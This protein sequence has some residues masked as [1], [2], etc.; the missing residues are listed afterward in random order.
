M[1]DPSADIPGAEPDARAHEATVWFARKLEG[2]AA[3]DRAALQAWL[4]ADPRNAEA[5]DRVE[6]TWS[7]LGR[8]GA[9]LRKRPQRAPLSRRSLGKTALGLGALGV[10]AGA[11]YLLM[12]PHPLADLR[13]AKGERR[14]DTL[15]DGTIV[16]LS[17]ATALTLRFTDQERRVVLHAGEAFFQVAPDPARPFV[18]EAARG[19]SIA[20]GTAY[21]VRREERAVTVTVVEHVVEVR[22]RASSA[23]VAAGQQVRYADDTGVEP[24][25]AAD[26]NTTLAWRGGQLVFLQRP[27]REVVAAIDAWRPGRTLLLDAG[28]GE[29]PVTAVI[30]VR[31]SETI[32]GALPRIAP[33]RI[34]H[35]TP[36][37]TLLYKDDRRPSAT[38]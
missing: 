3:Q 26:P 18:V 16:D 8:A 10:A 2:M 33:V 34:A 31:R 36:W 19:E 25:Q 7:A 21:A 4:A 5:L 38:P 6:R 28:L 17:T 1:S 37:L 23:L 15:A 30:D 32:L 11:G 9:D 24:T 29:L 22:H 27:L 14:A 20:L 13:S 12:P 35:V